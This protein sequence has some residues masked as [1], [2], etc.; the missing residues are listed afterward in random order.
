MLASTDPLTGLSN[1]RNFNEALEREWRRVAR[2]EAPVPLLII[3]IH[4][5]K[6]Y[7]DRHGHQ[8]GDQLLQRLSTGI[9]AALKR[10]GDIGARYGGDEFA[11]LLPATYADGAGRAEAIR[12]DFARVCRDSGTEAAALSIGVACIVPIADETAER[13]IKA[14]DGALYRAKQ[15]GRDR[16]EIALPESSAPV[17]SPI[18]A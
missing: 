18:A 4:L 7:N 2:E 15:E 10:G 8:A 16:I 13:L 3:D 12:E 9:G 5:F 17:L 11:V 6:D 14:A 1:R